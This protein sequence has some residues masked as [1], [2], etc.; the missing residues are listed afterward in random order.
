MDFSEVK[1]PGRYVIEAGA[2][3]T[4]PFQIGDNVWKGTIWKAIN[5]FFGERCGFAVPGSHGVDHLDWFATRG[6]TELL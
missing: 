4:R 2:L 1:T 6:T 5:F 3:R